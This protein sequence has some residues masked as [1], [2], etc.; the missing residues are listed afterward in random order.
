MSIPISEA[1][2]LYAV[3]SAL[4]HTVQAVRWLWRTGQTER[5]HYIAAH[6]Q[7]AHGQRLRYC[8]IDD[9]QKLMAS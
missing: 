4:T 8:Q 6:V 9:C 2:T 3:G 1:L 7:N 5:S